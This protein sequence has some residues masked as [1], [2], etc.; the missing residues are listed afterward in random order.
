ML[1]SKSAPPSKAPEFDDLE[2]ERGLNESQQEEAQRFLEHETMKTLTYKRL[3][4]TG[5]RRRMK[6]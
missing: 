2:V 5:T 1:K 3:N 6:N 4:L